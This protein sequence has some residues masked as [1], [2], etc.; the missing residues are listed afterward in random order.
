MWQFAVDQIIYHR[1]RSALTVAAIGAAIAVTLGLR[2]FELG[3]YQQ[4]RDAVLDRGGQLIMTQSGV[5]NFIAAR[6]TLP[7]Q[8]RADVEAIEGVKLAHPMTGFWVMY[9]PA[10]YRYPLLLMVY[11]TLGGPTHL[12][13]GRQVQG[14]RDMV[15]DIGFAKRFALQI[16]DPVVISGYAFRVVGITSGSAALFSTFGFINYD[17][18]ID[19]FLESEIAPDISTFPLLGIMLIELAEGVN[20]VSIRKIIEARVPAVDVYTP[21]ELAQQDVELGENLFGPIMGVLVNLSY[22]IGMLVI[23]LIIYADVNARRR[24]FGVM[25]ALGFPYRLIARSVILQ[26]L[27]LVGL[28]LPLGLCLGGLIAVVIDHYLPVYRVVILDI[29]GLLQTL[30]GVCVMSLL[31][32][33]LPLRVIA[34]TDPML[35]FQVE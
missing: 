5:S 11:D 25:K 1:I 15:V 4:S 8:V 31:G 21:A 28:A 16:G 20:P 3:L 24:N 14:S 6:S 29:G 9:G 2:G 33:L 17:G 12:I 27:I 30:L 13:A 22:L 10:G 19:L 23:G 26:T 34:R 18:L 7:Q 35:V 32:S